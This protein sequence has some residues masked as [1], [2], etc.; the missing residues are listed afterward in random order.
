MI[1]ELKGRG[2]QGEGQVCALVWK[3][4]TR[5]SQRRIM[6]LEALFSDGRISLITS[7][8]WFISSGMHCTFIVFFMCLFLT[9]LFN[10]VLLIG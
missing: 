8:V 10:D 9:C 1:C 3:S 4:L 6:K 5:T 2:V 7:T